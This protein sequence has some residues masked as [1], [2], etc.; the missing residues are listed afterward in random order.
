MMSVRWRSR[1]LTAWTALAAAFLYLPILVVIVYS[2]NTDRFLLQW[3]GAG[4]QGYVQ[5]LGN[6]ALRQALATSLVV[7]A[8]SAAGAVVVGGLAGFALARREGPWRRPVEAALLLVLVAPE[9]VVGLAY[10][11]AFVSVGLTWG[12]GRLVL[13]HMVFSSAVV[14]V[15]VRARLSGVD[16]ALEEAAADLGA[17]PLRVFVD[18]TLPAMRPALGAGALLAFTFSFDDVVTSAFVSTAGQVTLPVYIFSALRTGLKTE[19]AAITVLTFAGTVA[20]LVLAWWL[21]KRAS[22]RGAVWA[23]FAGH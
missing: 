22:G 17:T 16:A 13:G 21:L 5:A 12:L 2:F 9:I 14:T 7:A 18:V 1:A 19:H 23:S 20:A 4:V 3:S 11:I 8:T 10:L 6:R 15:I